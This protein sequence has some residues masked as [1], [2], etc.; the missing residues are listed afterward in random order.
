MQKSK[1][2]EINLTNEVEDLY[3]ENYKILLREIKLVINKRRD[4]SLVA[5]MV[6]NLPVIQETWVGRITWRNAWQPTPVFLPREPPWT[7]EPGGLQSMGSQRFR[8]DWATKY[9]QVDATNIQSYLQI[10][11][12]FYPDFNSFIEETKKPTLKAIWNYSMLQTVK[13]NLEN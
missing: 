6:K 2:L 1:M 8:H 11:H 9:K 3:T 13:G 7:E 12:N 5:Q 4:V 10:H